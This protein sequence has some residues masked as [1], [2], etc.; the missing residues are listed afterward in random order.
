MERTQLLQNIAVEAIPLSFGFEVTPNDKVQRLAAEM[1]KNPIPLNE[2]RHFFGD[3]C[4]VRELT[5]SKGTAVVGAKH[6]RRHVF[7][8]IKGWMWISDGQ[9]KTK[10]Q[11][12]DVFESLPGTQRA[13]WAPEVDC[14]CLAIHGTELTDPRALESEL[15]DMQRLP[16]EPVEKLI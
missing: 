11:A 15:V 12:G 7:A 5:V 8:V 10:V 1:A 16:H 4:Y 13:A 14:S 6:K 9:T 3:K 2:P